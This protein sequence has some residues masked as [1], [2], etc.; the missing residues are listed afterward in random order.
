MLGHLPNALTMF[1]IAIVPVVTWLIWLGWHQVAFAL[2]V[3]AIA[4]DMLDGAAARWLD[5][6]SELGKMLDPIAD[7]LLTACVLL[8]LTA[9]QTISGWQLIPALVILAREVLVSGLREY[10][11]GLSVSLPVTLATKSKTVLQ[12]A[13]LGLLILGPGLPGESRS[14]ILSGGYVLLWLAAALTAYTGWSYVRA[15]MRHAVD[16]Q[17]GRT[18]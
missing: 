3:L 17:N 9:S 12:F 11:A 13:A 8:V 14:S 10:L 18:E 2:F 15:S 16:A 6:T 1:R 7:K 5:K 4:T